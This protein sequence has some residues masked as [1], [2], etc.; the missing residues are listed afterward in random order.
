M[1]EITLSEMLPRV[2]VGE[3]IPNSAVWLT[4][5]TFRRGKN[6]LVEAPSGGG[7]SSLMSYLYGNRRDFKGKLLFNGVDTAALRL[8]DWQEIRRRHIAY[9]PQDLSLFPEL[10]AIDNIKL[11]NSLTDHLD[12]QRIME[13]MRRLGID[14]RADYPARKMSIGQ[15]QRLAIIR[16]LAMPFDFLILDEPVSHLDSANNLIAAEI[17]AEEVARQGAAVIS[18]SVG[19]P[20][21]LHSAIN[22]KL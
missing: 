19:N 5:L 9:L 21:L 6:Y 2:F 8:P 11:K 1:E 12:M 16:A 4:N 14:T 7:K 3:S 22:I 20:I 18:T 13:W 10:T 15:Q 17:I